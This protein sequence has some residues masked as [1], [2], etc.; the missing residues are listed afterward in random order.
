MLQTNML[1]TDSPPLSGAAQN[2]QAEGGGIGDLVN[3]AV[4]FLRRQYLVIIV[5]AAL[6]MAACVVYLRITPPTYSAQVLILLANPPQFVQQQSLAAPAFDLNQI[7]TQLQ[8]LKSSAIAVAVINQLKLEDDPDLNGSGLS[9]FSLWYRIRAWVSPRPKDRQFEAPNQPPEDV[10]KA[11][12]DRL[13]AYRVDFSN[14]IEVS[15]NSSSAKRAAEIANAAA[16]AYIAD[17]L[18]AK[19]EANRTATSWM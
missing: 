3:F 16:K 1:Q 13:S 4:A 2:G 19:C 8:I 15:F 11:F 12:Q 9:L 18:N 14:V 10:I 5:T 7:E 6:A 17:Q